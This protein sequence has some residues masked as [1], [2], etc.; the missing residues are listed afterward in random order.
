MFLTYTSLALGKY[1]VF[2]MLQVHEFKA[3][4]YFLSIYCILGH[5]CQFETKLRWFMYLF[6][7]HDSYVLL[8][9][10]IS[11]VTSTNYRAAIAFKKIVL[12]RKKLWLGGIHPH[13]AP[14]APSHG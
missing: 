14:L 7:I 5:M 1:F 9:L 10:G 11:L 12:N 8:L 2:Y 13:S 3:K 4:Y 6:S